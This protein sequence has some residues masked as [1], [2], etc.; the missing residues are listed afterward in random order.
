[1]LS[2]IHFWNKLTKIEK[3]KKISFFLA[4][5]QNIDNLLDYFDDFNHN[6]SKKT[7]NYYLKSVINP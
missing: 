4:D 3:Y 5:F 6:L 2:E 7:L 1:M